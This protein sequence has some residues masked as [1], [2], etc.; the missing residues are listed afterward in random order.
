MP[1]G[2]R[3]ELFL[4]MTLAGKSSIHYL[5]VTLA[6]TITQSLT[7]RDNYQGLYVTRFFAD[8]GTTVNVVS[9]RFSNGNLAADSTDLSISGYLV[10]TN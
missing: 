1:I 9:R 8:G 3:P 5:P 7:P 10:D 2:E 6:A 4:D